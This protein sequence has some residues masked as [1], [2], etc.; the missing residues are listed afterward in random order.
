MPVFEYKG[1]TRGNRAARGLVDAASARAAR[2]KLR[3]E[4]VFP[5]EITEGRTRSSASE[6]LARLRLPQLRRVPDLDL[7]LFT[8]Q[9]ATL[10]SAGVPLVDSLS[11]LTEQI[12]NE[13]LK[14]VTGQVR[15]AVNEGLSL[16]DALGAHPYVFSELYR[17][18]TR[19]GESSGALAVV[20][21]R[22]AEYIESQMELRNKM[23][24]AMVY[25]VLMIG[26]SA[27]VAGV[28]LVKVIPTIT[29][30]LEDLDQPLP[31]AT[32]VVISISEF[33]R[34]W[35]S[36]LA[37]SGF[38]AFLTFNRLIQT[39][40]GRLAWDRLRLALP[41]VGQTVRHVAIAR[42]TRTLSTLL[43]GGLRIVQA[44]DIAKVVTAN[45]VIGRAIERAR[46][47][48]T[49]GTSIAAPLRQSG[50]F[51]AMV[52]HMVAVGEA[53]GELEAM[54]AKVAET[55]DELV[56]NSLERLMA[57]MG[58]VLLILVA[59]VVV[60]IILSTLLPLLNLTAAL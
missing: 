41:V 8:R 36:A 34:H 35:W 57:L 56:D 15:A 30:L 49:R 14:K 52:T 20:L 46:D 18:M 5:T 37:L 6:L 47:A 42:F 10:I 54:L 13:K 3:S 21:E 22:L 17:G 55:Y 2:L 28:L 24:N 45:A 59:G 29:R 16:A 60:M 44:L 9:L 43:G 38:A 19:A 11:A 26:F 48:I 53:S 51:P 58:P 27:I 50:E 33:L 32:V 1:V 25:P 4:G 12:D 31:L 23:T 7:A 39:E 40:R